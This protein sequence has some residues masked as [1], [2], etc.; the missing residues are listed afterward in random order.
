MKKITQNITDILYRF[1]VSIVVGFAFLFIVSAILQAFLVYSFT[2]RTP[3]AIDEVFPR[4][5]I[6]IIYNNNETDAS[7]RAVFAS[8][9]RHTR[10]RIYSY[11]TLIGLPQNKELLSGSLRALDIKM[12]ETLIE[13]ILSDLGVQYISIYNFIVLGSEIV[14]DILTPDVV[15]MMQDAKDNLVGERYS[16]MILEVGYH[17]DSEMMNEFMR[18]LHLSL[19]RNLNYNFYVVGAS[20]LSYELRQSFTF[21]YLL[22]S[23]VLSVVLYIVLAVTYKKWILP[24]FLIGIVQTAIW[25]M[26]SV[27][28]LTNT[29][30][31]FLALLVV[32]AVI[33]GSALEWGVLLVNN[34]I[35]ARSTLDPKESLLIAF[36]RSWRIAATSSMIMVVVTLTLS[37]LMQGAV[38]AIMFGIGMAALG[39]AILTIIVL[40]AILVLFD[41]RIIK[42]QQ[43]V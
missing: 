22:I 35:E 24:L 3:N 26:M 21:D 18:N 1:K 19:N 41:K 42:N 6:S 2:E 31:Y 25:I 16:R 40:P 23:L 43:I 30:I 38:S 7:I 11:P 36:N 5:S 27:M 34:Y 15:R 37:L 20:A 39:A 8:I 29:P 17:I 32:Q 9:V 4:S 14:P 12:S 33:K 28:M 10:G 13:S